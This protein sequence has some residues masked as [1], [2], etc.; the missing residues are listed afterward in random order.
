MITS[1]NIKVKKKVIYSSVNL[2]MHCLLQSRLTRW[3]QSDVMTIRSDENE[4]SENFYLTVKYNLTWL[5]EKLFT[6]SLLKMKSKTSLDASVETMNHHQRS[7]IH[8]QLKMTWDWVHY[9][10]VLSHE[11][12]LAFASTFDENT[13]CVSRRCAQTMNAATASDHLIIMIYHASALIKTRRNKFVYQE[14]WVQSSTSK[15]REKQKKQTWQTWQWQQ[16]KKSNERYT[17]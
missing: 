1:K 2:I 11:A 14:S 17:S 12:V 10:I 5:K 3:R 16:R 6:L 9:A 7:M 15:T 4:R 13:T 8:R